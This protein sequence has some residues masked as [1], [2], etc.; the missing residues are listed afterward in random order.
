M[1]VPLA[2]DCNGYRI[3]TRCNEGPKDRRTELAR[4]PL[5]L[6]CCILFAAIKGGQ[7][8]EVMREPVLP[9]SSVQ[10]LAHMSSQYRCVWCDSMTQILG[11]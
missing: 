8:K 1:I 9:D 3:L 7:T 11:W 6:S 5:R 4:Y 10:R 2:P